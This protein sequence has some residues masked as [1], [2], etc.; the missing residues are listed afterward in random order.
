[1]QTIKVN[2]Q[3]YSWL[4]YKT[5]EFKQIHHFD[6]CDIDVLEIY[7]ADYDFH[8]VIRIDTAKYITVPDSAHE[9]DWL[10]RTPDWPHNYYISHRFLGCVL[11]LGRKL[12]KKYNVLKTG[13]LLFI[14]RPRVRKLYDQEI[15]NKHAEKIIQFLDSERFKPYVTDAMGTTIIRKASTHEVSELS[16]GSGGS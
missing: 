7:S 1:M 2:G 16:S 10:A 14:D 9:P 15:E 11:V 6:E 5:T 8:I 4:N 3:T 12:S 13:L